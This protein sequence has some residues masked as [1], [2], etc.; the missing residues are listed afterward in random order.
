MGDRSETRRQLGE[1]PTGS[2]K[3]AGKTFRV[4]H[5]PAPKTSKLPK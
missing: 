4:I 5:R 1:F 3:L 2:N